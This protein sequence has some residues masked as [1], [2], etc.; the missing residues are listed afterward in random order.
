[1]LQSSDIDNRIK[2]LLDALKMPSSAQDLG[3]YS[4]PDD[5]EALFFVLLED[6]AL[7]TRLSIETDMLLEPTSDAAGP[8][9]ARLVVKVTLTPFLMSGGNVGF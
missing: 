5:D 2:T 8:Q 1:V 4:T 6:D 3:P 7:V 9:D